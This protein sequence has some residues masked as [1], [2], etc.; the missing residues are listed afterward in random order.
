MPMLHKSFKPAKCKTALKMASSRIK[1]LRNKRDVQLRQ[2]KREVAQLLAAGHDRTARIR[3]EHVVNEE[4][5]MAAYE[6]IEIY[7]ELIVA[8][9]NMIESQKICPVDLK[10][11]ISS[12]MFATPRCA[13]LPELMDVKKNFTAKYGKDFVSAAI[14]L[15]PNSG[16]S[17][18]LVEKLSAKAP[19]GPEKMKILSAIA[20]EHN[21]KW[22]PKSFEDDIKPSEDLLNGPGTF[23][24]ESTM[25]AQTHNVEPSMNF[26]QSQASSRGRHDA[27]MN[28]YAPSSRPSSHMQSPSVDEFGA[29]NTK[30]SVS[31]RDQRTPGSRPEVVEYRH[32]HD[33]PGNLSSGSQQWNMEF[34]DATA[35]AQAAAESAERASMAARAAAELSTR[36]NINWQHSREQHFASGSLPRDEGHH[37]GSKFQGEE[38][39]KDVPNTSKRNSHVTN[40]QLDDVEED[41]LAAL[42]ERFNNLKSRLPTSE[43]SSPPDVV[44]PS[45]SNPKTMERHSRKSSSESTRSDISSDTSMKRQPS[46]Q[47]VHIGSNIHG[48]IK[49]GTGDSFQESSTQEQS[50]S[51]PSHPHSRIP[52]VDENLASNW[53]HHESSED[54]IGDPF[55]I[56]QERSQAN[57]QETSSYDIATAAFDDYGSDD[58]AYDFHAED[59]VKV[60]RSSH[61]PSRKN[62]WSPGQSM[63]ES[64]RKSSSSSIFASEQHPSSVFSGGSTT[65]TAPY[66]PDDF[67]PVTFDDSD[68]PSS[69]NEEDLSK[70]KVGDPRITNM[71]SLVDSR[72]LDHSRNESSPWRGP[73]PGEKDN[74]EQN[75][76]NFSRPSSVDFDDGQMHHQIKQEVEAGGK[77]DTQFGYSNFYSDHPSI[78]TAESQP[79]SSDVNEN[80]QTQGPPSTEDYDGSQQPRGYMDDTGSVEQSDSESGLGLNFGLLAGG[81]RNKGYKHPPY[82]SNVARSSLSKH[83]LED[84]S[85]EH[86]TYLRGNVGSRE[87]REETS[88]K[89]LNPEV[90]TRTSPRT[91]VRKHS[92]GGGDSV[93]EPFQ[94]KFVSTEKPHTQ[95]SG[96]EVNKLSGSRTYFDSDDS[97][98][99]EDL[100]KQKPTGK[101]IPAQIFSRRTKASAAAAAASN[102]DGRSSAKAANTSS[103]PRGNVN[104]RR[105]DEPKSSSRGYEADEVHRALEEHE[106]K[107]LPTS[108]R[109]SHGK[110][111]SYGSAGTHQSQSKVST[112]Q[113]S[114]GKRW[115]TVEASPQAAPE[116]S[117][118]SEKNSL[119]SSS[120]TKQALN[121]VAPETALTGKKE[122]AKA[123]GSAGETP[124]RQDSINR[125]SHVHPKLPDYDTF[126]AHLLSLRQNRQ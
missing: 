81:F 51:L 98:V 77:P 116:F 113:M 120:G 78:R 112:S 99:G 28:S 118:S 121:H 106:S 17:R 88:S 103:R 97:D 29:G 47:E 74:V 31:H 70:A 41:E 90:S 79:K 42:S 55:F 67:L 49:P 33:R 7:C 8:R 6:L 18:L 15:R 68:G 119:R 96:G 75:R 63:A 115:S 82:R 66:Q 34:K 14:E 40:E 60:Q 37:F 126:A 69:E 125:A 84:T 123:S 3:V 76:K 62:A 21:V 94:Q 64:P 80:L 22:D 54:T 19:D 38:L 56:S 2:L 48:G 85:T 109:S 44:S 10:E 27:S 108:E 59:E 26:N 52:R 32:T 46:D 102:S 61:V 5:T 50:T 25:H 91:Q 104:V 57:A 39:S 105:A 1:L 12:V 117:S 16:V 124:S 95:G 86:S 93:E 9:L 30:P 110:S 101:T 58:D 87:N 107:P 89:V 36:D 65:N 114:S 43:S 122:S 100:S 45:M 111:S 83:S 13:D 4:K 73:L 20:Q 72:N 71:S 24:H 35:A 11:A 23:Q 53:D 92:L